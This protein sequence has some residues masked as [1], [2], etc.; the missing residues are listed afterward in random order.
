MTLFCT[1][2]G[3]YRQ[4]SAGKCR[5][6]KSDRR[7]VTNRRHCDRLA[8]LN[9]VITDPAF[10]TLESTILTTENRPREIVKI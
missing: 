3:A 8:S 10:H 2:E 5:V 1:T 4:R 7:K 6:S 9:Q